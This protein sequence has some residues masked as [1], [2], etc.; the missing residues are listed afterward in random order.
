MHFTLVELSSL[1]MGRSVVVHYTNGSRMVCA[2]ILP[3]T[4][5]NGHWT[6]AKATFKGTVSGTITLRQQVFPD[7]GSSD[8]TLNVDLK[9]SASQGIPAASLFITSNRVN[10]MSGLCTSVGDTFNPFNMKLLSSSCSLQNQLSCAVGEF[11]ARQGNVSLTGREVYTDSNIQLSGDH[12]VV[13]RSLVLTSGNNILGCANILPESP[14]AKQTFIKVRSFSRY[15]FRRRV[16]DVLQAEM[17]RITIL[18]GSPFFTKGGKC[19]TVN[20]MVS[21]NVSTQLLKSVGSSQL[22][23]PFRGKGRCA[24]A[25]LISPET[26]AGQLVLLEIF[27]LCL[28]CAAAFLL[29]SAASL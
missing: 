15:D 6:L 11:S 12:T 26:S 13:Y 22:M 21:G 20:F 1:I 10:A 8:V 7:G 19:Q 24:S 29:P 2:N 9:S 4:V 14:S 27:S 16:A 17:A 3:D 25:G 23:G 28:M 5:I 18:P